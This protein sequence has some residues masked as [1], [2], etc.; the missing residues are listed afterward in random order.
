MPYLFS[1]ILAQFP[2]TIVLATAMQE[3][4][5]QEGFFEK[6]FRLLSLFSQDLDRPDF[7]FFEVGKEQVE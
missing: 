4:D 7:L 1:E 3:R 6:R 5:L 2:K